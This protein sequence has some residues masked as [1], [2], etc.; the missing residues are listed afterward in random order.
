MKPCLTFE[1][2]KKMVSDAELIGVTVYQ[3][4]GLV[5]TQQGNVH[6]SF[7]DVYDLGQ[8]H[9]ISAQPLRG[10]ED[11]RRPELRTAPKVDGFL[12]PMWDGDAI[13][14]ECQES[15]NALSA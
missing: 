5:W 13:R 2:L 4:N 9:V 8:H 12:G 10:R 1:I 14:Y 6:N 15:Y 7:Y 3:K 11:V